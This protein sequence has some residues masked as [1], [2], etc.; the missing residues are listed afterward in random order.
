MP[1]KRPNVRSEGTKPAEGVSRKGRVQ[2]DK[3]RMKGPGR[4]IAAFRVSGT[5]LPVSLNA[6]VSA[7]FGQ[8]LRSNGWG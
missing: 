5:L 4:D 2:A 6:S 8:H 7:K 1:V 3:G